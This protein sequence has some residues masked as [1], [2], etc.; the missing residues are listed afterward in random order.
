M[1]S[2][3]CWPA[4]LPC[5]LLQVLSIHTTRW[6]LDLNT[7]VILECLSLSGSMVIS[8]PASNSGHSLVL[9]HWS[10][11][12]MDHSV[13]MPL[14]KF[15]IAGWPWVI[16]QFLWASVAAWVAVWKDLSSE[17]IDPVSPVLYAA[18]GWISSFWS[19]GLLCVWVGPGHH[20]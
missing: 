15:H 5:L 6:M 18:A 13:S 9:V 17:F 7:H 14:K 16:H 19:S 8:I 1:E 11:S 10:L 12:H 20:S 3:C 2:H 4:A